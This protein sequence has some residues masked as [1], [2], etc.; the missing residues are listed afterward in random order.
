MTKFL[1]SHVKKIFYFFKYHTSFFH[2]KAYNA[3]ILSRGENFVNTGLFLF[4]QCVPI[5]LRDISKLR[6]S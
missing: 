5:K 2:C 4:L 1:R 6:N 3:A